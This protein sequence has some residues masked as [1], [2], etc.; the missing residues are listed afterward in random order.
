M[1]Y[2]V[3][4][5]GLLKQQDKILFDKYCINGHTYYALPGGKQEVGESFKDCVIRE[6]NPDY[7]LELSSEA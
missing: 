6:F 4:A 1:I 2:R 5:R 7:A 3:T